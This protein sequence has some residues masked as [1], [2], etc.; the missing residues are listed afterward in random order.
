MELF[1][2]KLFL[3]REL[4]WLAFN[5]HVLDEAKDVSLPLYERLKFFGIFA[6]NLDEF[7]M[8]RVAGLKK[9]IASKVAETAADGLLPSEQLTGI[10]ERTHSMAAEHG[11]LWREELLPLLTANKLEIVSASSLTAEQRTVAH[12][13]FSSI[14]FPALTPLAVDP[15]HPFP[16]LRN[17]SLN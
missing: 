7:F 11:R 13:H 4:S 15:G 8:V 17:K 2:P 10:R 16:H 5:G 9:Q 6:S 12:H 3:N 14:A 1:D